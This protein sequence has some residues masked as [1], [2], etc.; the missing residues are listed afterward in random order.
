MAAKRIIPVVE[1]LYH[2]VG[3]ESMIPD[4]NIFLIREGTRFTIFDAGIPHYYRDSVD[5]IEEIGLNLAGLDRIILTHTHL[6]HSGSTPHF[7]EDAKDA[8]LWVSRIEGEYLEQGDDTIVYGSMLGQRLPPL[9]VARKLEEGDVITVG[10]FTFQVLLTPGHSIGSLCFFEPTQGILISG[11]VVMRHGSFGRVDLPTGNATHLKESIAR[12]A[13]LPVQILLP[14]HMGIAK[15]N[16]QR[17]IQLSLQFA[18][19]YL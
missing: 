5:A 13:E 7:L 10:D 11:D 17:E 15:E 6:D 12:L 19:Q 3:R 2:I 18:R 4:S 8:E 9:S 16:P 14:G 1:G